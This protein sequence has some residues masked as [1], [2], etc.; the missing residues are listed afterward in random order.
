ML[1]VTDQG[2]QVGAASAKLQGTNKELAAGFR[3]YSRLSRVP[4]LLPHY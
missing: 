4:L 3:D 2:T 1:G